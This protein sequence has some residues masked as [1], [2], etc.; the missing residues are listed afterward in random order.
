MAAAP[1]IRMDETT[2]MFEARLKNMNDKCATVPYR[3]LM[4]SRNVLAF[5]AFLFDCLKNLVSVIE[6]HFAVG[7]EL[8]MAKLLK[9][10]ICVLLQ[11]A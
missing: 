8:T 7:V 6:S 2:K 5:G 4:I 11:A 10:I 3:T 9:I 1:P